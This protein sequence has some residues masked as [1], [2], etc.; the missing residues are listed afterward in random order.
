MDEECD[1]DNGRQSTRVPLKSTSIDTEVRLRKKRED[2]LSRVQKRRESE[3]NI[4]RKQFSCPDANIARFIRDLDRTNEVSDRP[5]LIEMAKLALAPHPSV[6]INE[7][8]LKLMKYIVSVKDPGGW[9]DHACVELGFVEPLIVLLST[10]TTTEAM[11][12]AAIKTLAQLAAKT[13]SRSWGRFYD[14]VVR[15]VLP[16]VAATNPTSDL[17][18]KRAAACQTI[19]DAVWTIMHDTEII[20]PTQ[21]IEEFARVY[22]PKTM[23]FFSSPEGRTRTDL[24]VSLIHATASVG[25]RVAVM[26]NREMVDVRFLREWIPGLAK[27]GMEILADKQARRVLHVAAL[28]AIVAC[29]ELGDE[30]PIKKAMVCGGKLV[31]HL[32]GSCLTVGEDPS[33]QNQMYYAL[34]MISDTVDPEISAEL[35]RAGAVEHCALAALKTNVAPKVRLSAMKVVRD[36]VARERLAHP[37]ISKFLL[38]FVRQAFGEESAFVSTTI[39][40]ELFAMLSE[41]LEIIREHSDLCPN[42]AGD[43]VQWIAAVLETSMQFLA[44]DGEDEEGEDVGG[45]CTR[46][47]LLVWLQ[48]KIENLFYKYAL[49]REMIQMDVGMDDRVTEQEMADFDEDLDDAIQCE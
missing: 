9:K 21:H 40:R 24:L 32:L 49:I 17:S 37:A 5:T 15:L 6:G 2:T 11:Q 8:Q 33:G 16:F 10:P 35:T 44:G 4:S 30:C 22:W 45:L 23:Q 14:Q 31:E 28:E 43:C 46:R 19:S 12:C 36:H 1:D 42:L 13:A 39:C 3:L 18:S 34:E 27:I 20:I 48:E 25:S 41:Y 26:V 38:E 47:M 7:W 29:L